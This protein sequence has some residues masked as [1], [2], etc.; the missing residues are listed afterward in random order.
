MRIEIDTVCLTYT[1]DQ[2][3]R[4]LNVARATAYQHVR[5]GVIPA[6]R[7]GR[8]WVI[9]RKRFHAWLEGLESH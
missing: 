8:R 1:V 6:E 7:L 2:V 9:P 4:L 5:D 3:A